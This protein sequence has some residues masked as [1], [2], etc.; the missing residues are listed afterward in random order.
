[1]NTTTL[2]RT[3]SSSRLARVFR[4][5]MSLLAAA[6][7]LLLPVQRAAAQG[8][9]GFI[10]SP[11]SSE[12]FNKSITTLKPTYEQR[13]AL[14][15]A[16][17]AYKTR[18]RQLR[19]SEAEMILRRMHE[20]QSNSMFR[21]PKKRD[22]EELLRMRRTLI[23]QI[24]AMEGELFDRMAEALHER[25]MGGLARIR[26]AR[27]RAIWSEGDMMSG[28]GGG[29]APDLVNIVMS[30]Q[31][32]DEE[33]GR[34]DPA[35]VEYEISMNAAVKN[36][37]DKALGM[38]SSVVDVMSQ[39]G[40]DEVDIT[41]QDQMMEY[42]RRIQ[43]A[44]QRFMKEVQDAAARVDAVGERGHLS[45]MQVM[46]ASR[47]PEYEK[48]YLRRRYPDVFTDWT[49][50][51]RMF[52]QARKIEGLDGGALAAIDA[53]EA[54][55]RPQYEA[56]SK[57]L[58]TISDKTRAS[59][60]ASFDFDGSAWEAIWRDRQAAEQERNTINQR[61]EQALL[62]ALGEE[63]FQPLQSYRG[64]DADA[65]GHGPGAVL[66]EAEGGVMVGESPEAPGMGMSMM[67][68]PDHLLPAPISDEEWAAY[69]A[70]LDLSPDARV[71]T[72]EF[73]KEYRR[74]FDAVMA[75]DFQRLVNEP[76]GK[77]WGEDALN[78]QAASQVIAGR[79]TVAQRLAALEEEFFGDVALVI[80]D[81]QRARLPMIRRARECMIYDAREMAQRGYQEGAV[82]LMELLG[83]LR[84]TDAETRSID[85]A[86]LKYEEQLLPI[87]KSQHE[88]MLAQ[89]EAQIKGQ[90]LM[91]KIQQDPEANMDAWAEWERLM[92]PLEERLQQLTRRRLEL[93]KS[94]LPEFIAA[95][96]PDPA[97]RL[98]ELHDQRR[99][100]RVFPDRGD[101]RTSVES[102]LQ[103]PD[104][105]P[106]QRTTLERIA[107]EHD[108]GHRAL[109]Q[110]MVALL[111]SLGESPDWEPQNARAIM[112]WQRNQERVEIL[113]L[114]RAEFNETTRRRLRAVLGEPQAARVRGL[115][116]G[117]QETA[118]R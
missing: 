78:E 33:L 36:L 93:D 82:N 3:P 48:A 31:L 28:M 24:M 30:L 21:V 20:V 61:A 81:A 41:D 85:A 1:M 11:F 76:R 6:L 113:Q 95:L 25:Q 101:A 110:E 66:D 88:T 50:P 39:M 114:D 49:S 98:K 4:S 37:H 118:S 90:P 60:R 91:R 40:L 8:G 35:L 116:V 86:L 89:E 67:I 53:A 46:P 104:L 22:V 63:R 7:C 12:S 34:I 18:F 75:D 27:E 38:I 2:N 92:E 73:L 111:D 100:P 71:L 102:A 112:E 57:K 74:Q 68:R 117:S 96:P 72:G 115:G 108:A 47:V 23:G 80:T 79:R 109:C 106:A 65:A 13:L 77:M 44:M 105:S 55:W 59:Q 64:V 29:D 56:A 51:E 9:D 107:A 97:A 84:L 5:G 70:R 87:V 14:E 94:S 42:G 10:P 16:H 32:T 99:Y 45:L 43:E 54:A 17:E 19:D 62:A 58:M 69:A 83:S 52:E 26:R 15:A 103:L